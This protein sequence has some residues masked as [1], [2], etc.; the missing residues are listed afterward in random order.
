MAHNKRL[1]P[2]KA[3]RLYQYTVASICGSHYSVKPTCCVV[4]MC[5]IARII[6]VMVELFSM[7]KRC[8]RLFYIEMNS[9]YIIDYIFNSK[10]TESIK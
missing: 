9:I 5:I 10:T 4:F 1:P 8:S 2:L 6:A 3:I 7:D